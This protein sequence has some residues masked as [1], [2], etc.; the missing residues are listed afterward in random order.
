MVVAIIVLITLFIVL[1]TTTSIFKKEKDDISGRID[2]LGDWDNDHVAN[3]F[4]KCPCKPGDTDNKGCPGEIPDKRD[5]SCLT[6]T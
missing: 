2:G 3:M 6:R 1:F 5:D 4:D